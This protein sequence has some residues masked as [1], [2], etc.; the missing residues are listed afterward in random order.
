[1]KLLRLV[2]VLLILLSTPMFLVGLL[3]GSPILWAGS[4]VVWGVGLLGYAVCRIAG[5]VKK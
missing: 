3:N 1:M 5:K 4:F 2:A